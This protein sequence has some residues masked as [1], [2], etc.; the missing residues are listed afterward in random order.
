L[1]CGPEVAPVPNAM[2]QFTVLGE[3]FQTRSK[4]CTIMVFQHR[5]SILRIVA[6]HVEP[7]TGSA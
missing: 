5:L 4:A 6:R 3:G 7:P 2:K 1:L